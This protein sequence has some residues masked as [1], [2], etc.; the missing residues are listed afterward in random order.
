M[1]GATTAAYVAAAAVAASAGVNAYTAKRE[2]DRQ[3]HAAR[4]QLEQQERMF[5]EEDQ[6]RNKANRKQANIEGILGDSTI[7][8]LGDT[9]LT[10]SIGAP[11]DPNKLGKGSSLL[12]G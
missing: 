5:Q 10:G 2:G 9:A 7:E 8:G 3:E 12:G 6:A 11:I 4:Q 1:S